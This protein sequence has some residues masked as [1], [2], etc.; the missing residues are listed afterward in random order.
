[1]IIRFLFVNFIKV[2]F[3]K[4]G[5]ERFIAGSRFYFMIYFKLHFL[6]V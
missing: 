3:E 2:S 6:K 1:M 4:I 5:V